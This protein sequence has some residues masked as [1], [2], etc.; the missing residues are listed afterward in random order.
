MDQNKL[1]ESIEFFNKLKIFEEDVTTDLEKTQG[2]FAVVVTYEYKDYS[3]KTKK[4]YYKD[5]ALQGNVHNKSQLQ[6]YFKTPVFWLDIETHDWPHGKGAE[7]EKRVIKDMFDGDNPDFEKLLKLIANNK[8][9]GFIQ[10]ITWEGRTQMYG[11]NFENNNHWHDL[12]KLIQYV[13]KSKGKMPPKEYFSR[14]VFKWHK[15]GRDSLSPDLGGR[16]MI[17][18]LLNNIKFIQTK[19]SKMELSKILLN[20]KQ[21]ILQGPPG[22]GKT[23]TSKDL[24]EELIYSKISVDKKIQK[25][26]LEN[27][28]QFKLIQFHPSYSYEDFV[29]GITAKSKDGVI[30]Y[31]TENKVLA[32]FAKKAL[33]NFNDTNK[34]QIEVS[35]EKWIGEQFEKFIDFISDNIERNGKIEITESVNIIKLDEDAFRYKGID[36]WSKNGNRMLFEDIK[37]AYLDENNDRQDVKHNKDLSGLAK[38]HASYYIRVLDKFR[39]FLKD[40]NIVFVAN[41]S[42]KEKLKNY[43]LIIDEINRANLPAVLGELIYA[44]EY[45]GEK[46]ESMY[47]IDGDNTLIIPPNLFII[48]TMNTADRSV[49]HIDYA[50]RRRFAFVDVL[51]DA[52]VIENLN[53]RALFEEISKLFHN[54][55]TLASDFKP[56]QVQLGHSYFI[57][58]DDTE[59]HLKAKYEIIPILE[60]YLKDGILLEKAEK[61]ISDLRNRFDN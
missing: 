47:D 1:L 58:K 50:I 61:I 27:S 34:E 12:I 45:R 48:G 10:E 19:L 8:S 31:I 7:I 43:V 28:D 33:K 40:N 35:K 6:N 49:G 20:K 56:T 53:A 36:G 2:Y 11:H 30:E 5:I 16:K 41:T 26:N 21:I 23:Y 44:L 51:P 54:N 60:E 3:C 13:I 17:W 24:A 25:E 38:W 37:Q 4:L 39:K 15:E 18:D 14:L 46:V 9:T 32:K 59:L 57:V 29:R 55:E 42:E 52:S 22:T